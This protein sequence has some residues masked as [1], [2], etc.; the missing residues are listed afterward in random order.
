[1]YKKVYYGRDITVAYTGHMTW[2]DQ[3]FSAVMKGLLRL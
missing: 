2:M 3:A 1:M